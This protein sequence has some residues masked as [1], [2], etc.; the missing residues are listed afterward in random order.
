LQI[1]RIGV[2]VFRVL[3]PERMK[4]WGAVG[5]S[6]MESSIEIVDETITIKCVSIPR[7]EI[8]KTLTNR[9][10]IAFFAA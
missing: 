2:R 6:L 8:L 9:M 5:M 7:V 4:N 10:S 1:K 3:E